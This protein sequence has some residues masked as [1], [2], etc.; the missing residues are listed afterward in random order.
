MNLP[1]PAWAGLALALGSLPACGATAGAPLRTYSRWLDLL[2]SGRTRD[3]YRLMSDDF[4]ATCDLACFRRQVERGRDRLD[5][6]RRQVRAQPPQV[7]L[8]ATLGARSEPAADRLVL[9]QEFIG[10]R[11][12]RTPVWRI[13]GDPLDFYPQGSAAEAL[14][15]FVRAADGRRY[16]ILLRF[17]PLKLR[18]KTTVEGLRAN[19]EGPGRADLQRQLAA[20]KAHLAL[21]PIVEGGEARL[22]VGEQKEARLLLED[23]AW[24]VLRLE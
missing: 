2:A 22:P 15:S 3:A 20:L 14:R 21:P 8:R 11:K 13:S 19:W 18:D 23:G 6:A 10:G 7:E 5:A 12:G 1:W 4:Q 17:V 16:E 9:V 24:H